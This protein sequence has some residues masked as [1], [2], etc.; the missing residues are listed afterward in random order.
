MKTFFKVILALVVVLAL[1]GVAQTILKV[2]LVSLIRE[3]FGGTELESVRV[4]VGQAMVTPKFE[5]VSLE[6]FYP[7]NLGVI[8]ANKFEW[9]RLN[10][11]TVFVFVEYDTYLR[12]GVRNPDLIKIERIGDTVYVDE[13]TIVI[14][15]LDAKLTNYKHIRTF[16]SNPL[17][18]NNAAEE[19]IFKAMNEL[20][21]ELIKKIE[22]NS[23]T[24]FEAAKKNFMENYQ[25][26]CKAMDLEVVWRQP[27]DADVTPP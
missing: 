21:T 3:V 18:I 5:I 16:T 20:E 4:N 2:N 19:F 15:L 8:E 13:S 11:G 14:E 22:G 10:I 25:N 23:Q 24:N 9:W 12:L 6:I 27:E 17:V 7:Q 1:L 26:L